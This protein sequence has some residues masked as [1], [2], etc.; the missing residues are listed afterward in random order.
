[1]R[2]PFFTRT[3]PLLVATTALCGGLAQA[4][5]GTTLSVQFSGMTGTDLTGAECAQR[6]QVLSTLLQGAGYGPVRM[7]AFPDG[8]L[9]ARWYHAGSQRTVLV[10]SGQKMT[11]NVFGASEYAGLVRLNEF[12]SS[13]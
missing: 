2:T 6:L 10:F 8:T 5:Q 1:M 4:N 7:L 3:S 12:Q 13:P 11:G 9:V